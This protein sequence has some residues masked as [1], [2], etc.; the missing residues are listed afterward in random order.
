MEFDRRTRSIEIVFCAR[1]D[2]AVAKLLPKAERDAV[3]RKLRKSDVVRRGCF[4]RPEANHFVAGA[5][6]TA[7]AGQDNLYH[8]DRTW[9]F[10]GAKA[11]ELRNNRFMLNC[12]RATEADEEAVFDD[13]NW[14]SIERQYRKTGANKLRVNVEVWPKSLAEQQRLWTLMV[15]VERLGAD[16]PLRLLD[17]E[18]LRMIAAG[19]R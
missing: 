13:S 7:L 4:T 5:I 15:T 12:I 8:L 11:S 16:S 2:P 9:I 1:T 18:V 6:R 19:V 3:N 14:V 10:G 17:A